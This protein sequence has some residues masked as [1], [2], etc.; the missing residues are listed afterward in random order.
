VIEGWRKLH[1]EELH[2]LYSLP[3][4]TKMMKFRAM[5]WPGYVARMERS[6]MHIGFRWESQ[7]VRDH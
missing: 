5:R 2:N 1:D 6:E 3:G 4:L 7:K